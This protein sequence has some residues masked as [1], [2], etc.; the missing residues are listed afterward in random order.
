MFRFMQENMPLH[1]DDFGPLDE[2]FELSEAM[3][4]AITQ[5]D[6]FS[7]RQLN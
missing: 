6:N 1:D 7:G 5:G 4:T 2:N 3:I